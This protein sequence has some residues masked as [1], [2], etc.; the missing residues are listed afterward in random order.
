MPVWQDIL[1][2]RKKKKLRIIS[3]HYDSLN[4]C[5]II[6]LLFEGFTQYAACKGRIKGLHIRNLLDGDIHNMGFISN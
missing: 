1:G 6:S 4:S 5:I 3:N 2:Q